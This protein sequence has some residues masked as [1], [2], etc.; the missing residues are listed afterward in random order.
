MSFILGFLSCL[1]LVM[2]GALA[3]IKWLEQR[4]KV[5]TIVDSVVAKPPN[6]DVDR[7]TPLSDADGRKR[8]SR[9]IGESQWDVIEQ[10]MGLRVGA[11]AVEKYDGSGDDK[12]GRISSFCGSSAVHHVTCGRF[13]LVDPLYT[14]TERDANGKPYEKSLPMVLVKENRER[15]CRMG[16]RVSDDGLSAIFSEDDETAEKKEV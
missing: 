11:S 5:V 16:F 12:S 14:A 6:V 2:C 7:V 1:L 10:R 3:F 9:L 13:S 15:L 8:V 4:R